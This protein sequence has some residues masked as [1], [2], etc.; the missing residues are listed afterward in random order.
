MDNE[1]RM[2]EI[3]GQRVRVIQARLWC[4]ATRPDHPV[5]PPI[6]APVP[7]AQPLTKTLVPAR[8]RAASQERAFLLGFAPVF[9]Q[10]PASPKGVG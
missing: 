3:R 9:D 4:E 1:S 6:L 7:A 5:I 10:A 8:T 2:V